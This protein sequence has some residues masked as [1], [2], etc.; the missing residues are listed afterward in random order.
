MSRIASHMH[1]KV[2]VRCLYQGSL[3]RCCKQNANKSRVAPCCR[4]PQRCPPLL[5][6]AVAIGEGLHLKEPGRE[7]N[8]VI[9]L[10]PEPYL[11]AHSC[12]CLGRCRHENAGSWQ[13]ASQSSE[14]ERQ[15][16]ARPGQQGR[17]AGCQQGPDDAGVTQACRSMQRCAMLQ[18][19]ERHT[20]AGCTCCSGSSS[21]LAGQTAAPS[22]RPRT[23]S[24]GIGIGG[25][26][27]S[28]IHACTHR[29][30]K[31]RSLCTCSSAK[32]GSAPAAS[33]RA[34]SDASHSLAAPASNSACAALFS[35]MA[36]PCGGYAAGEAHCGER[37]S[38]TGALQRGGAHLAGAV[39]GSGRHASWRSGGVSWGASA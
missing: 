20:S 28:H 36:A 12:R 24:Q 10:P 34:T 26:L 29:S 5:G 1:W 2:A 6:W 25:T 27:M 14:M 37:G 38:A 18:A 22:D 30:A 7:L 39:A 8:T 11:L 33:R 19:G 13:L 31:Q 9:N 32:L 3:R 17:C 21:K 35:A 16:A 4:H 15:L 23:V